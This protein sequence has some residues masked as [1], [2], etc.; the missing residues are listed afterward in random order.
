MRII[1]TILL[2]SSLH[3]AQIETENFQSVKQAVS[4]DEIKS[5][6]I[7]NLSDLFT[8]ADKWNSYSVDGFN[9]YLSS[10]NLSTYQRQ[11]F[12]LMIDNQKTD[13]NSFDVQNINLLPVSVYDIDYVEFINLPMIYEGEFTSSGL[14]HIHTKKP[15]E[16]L[17]A[18]A[19]FSLGNETG[20]PGPYKFTTL[21]TPNIDKLNYNLGVTVNYGSQNWFVKKQVRIGR[22]SLKPHPTTPSPCQ[23]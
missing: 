18:H 12:I 3:F 4:S 2:L 7:I 15:E 10:N 22:N 21:Q 19:N 6:G 11:N 8:L 20:D 14:I 1:F 16:K 9:Q 23:L 5:M 17:T 13:L